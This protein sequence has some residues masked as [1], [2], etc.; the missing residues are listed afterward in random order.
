MVCGLVAVGAGVAGGIA[1]MIRDL[2]TTAAAHGGGGDPIA[3]LERLTKA[4]TEFTKALA[5]A[6]Q[7]LALVVIGFCALGFGGWL[8]GR[9]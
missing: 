1:T 8:V 4:L 6:P 5:A 7:W 9:G 2:R 3:A